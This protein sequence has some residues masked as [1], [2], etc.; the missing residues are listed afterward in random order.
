MDL[1]LHKKKMHLMSQIKKYI[2]INDSELRKD[3]FSNYNGE[4]EYIFENQEI[5]LSVRFEKNKIS[6][7]LCIYH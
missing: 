5:F 6:D 3:I 1:K 2:L 7:Y 4:S